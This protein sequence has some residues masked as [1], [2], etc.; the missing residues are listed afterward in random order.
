MCTNAGVCAH[1]FMSGDSKCDAFGHIHN[2]GLPPDGEYK[3]VW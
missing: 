1:R 2:N 3:G